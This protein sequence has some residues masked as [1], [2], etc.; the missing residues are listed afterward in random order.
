[1]KMDHP[2]HGRDAKDQ[3]GQDQRPKAKSDWLSPPP[4]RRRQGMVLH[5]HR[6]PSW[7]W[8]C[9]TETGVFISTRLSDS[10]FSDLCGTILWK[11]SSDVWLLVTLLRERERERERIESFRKLKVLHG[12]QWLW[13]S[14]TLDPT[15][16]RYLS[17]FLRP[18]IFFSWHHTTFALSWS[19]S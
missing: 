15:S 18:E 17:S 13:W 19:L 14:M 10:F 9:V 11:L 8:F 12:D 16:Q 2:P 5:R 6:S 7:Q 1:M 3:Q 4:S